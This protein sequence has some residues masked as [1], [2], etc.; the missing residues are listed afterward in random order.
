MQF[1]MTGRASPIIIAQQFLRNALQGR[2][3]ILAKQNPEKRY[4]V[5]RCYQRANSTVASILVERLVASRATSFAHE[6]TLQELKRELLYVVSFARGT[7]VFD[8]Q[9]VKEMDAD[10]AALLLH[11]RWRW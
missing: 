1:V 8:L 6:Q 11:F 10:G 3:T 5:V 2:A 7:V 4:C 9:A